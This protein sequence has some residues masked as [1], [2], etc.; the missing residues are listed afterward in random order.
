MLLLGLAAANATDVS[1]WVRPS[2]EV[3]VRPDAI[4]EDQ[5]QF[6]TSAA[7]AGLIVEG[8]AS[9][10][11]SGRVYL[12]LSRDLVDAVTS[13]STVDADNNGTI[14][15]VA[16]STRQVASSLVREASVTWQPVEAAALKAGHQPIPFTS[17][18]QS[19]DTSLL[20]ATR[21]GP[22]SAFIADDDL[23][24]LFIGDMVG[25]A[26]VQG[27]AFMGSA[28]GP[29][30][31][32]TRGGLYLARIDVH[33]LGD[34]EHDET[35]GL[36][37]DLRVGFGAGLAWHPY[38]GFDSA[39]YESIRVNDVRAAGSARI[40]VAGFSAGAE[41]LWR[42][43]TNDL[44]HRPNEALGG[45]IQAGFRSPVDFE[46][47]VRIGVTDEDRTFDPQRTRWLDIGA[48]WYANDQVKLSGQYIGEHRLTEGELAH[49][50]RLALQ[51]EL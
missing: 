30:L 10:T 23:G 11:V 39:G 45:Y 19:A 33:P 46:P 32:G 7:N 47:V 25:V 38:V 41:V 51:A 44:N 2:A 6:G 21:S 1:A 49:G 15:G 20:F 3:V 13:V 50:A 43:E 34:F 5:L 42:E 27:G 48:N 28:A 14:D 24:A 9:E 16:T 12:Q 31:P 22:N 35:V 37:Q 40:A 36:D 18:S 17:Q 8:D 29:Q 26:R 4:P